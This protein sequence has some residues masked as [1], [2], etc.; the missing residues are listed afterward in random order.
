[1]FGAALDSIRSA[2]APAL[3]WGRRVAAVAPQAAFGLLLL[4]ILA[5]AGYFA[6]YTLSGLDLVGLL[7]DVNVDDSFYYFQIARNLA[8]GQFSTVD[9][10]ITRTN[11]YHPVWM[12]LITP[13]YWVL[14]L[15]TALFGI[16]ALELG[17]IGGSVVV[18]AAAARLCRLPWVA[19]VA[20]PLLL[21]PQ[22]ALWFGLEAACG[23]F[24][25]SL[26]FLALSLLARNPARW[27]PLLAATAFLLP[28]VRLEYLAISLTATAGS[29]IVWL[30][31]GGG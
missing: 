2:L 31:R 6:Y 13:F 30:T 17:L 20:L 11:G 3:P 23:L 1:M 26:L 12:L 22:K 24:A 8:E 15:E 21:Y 7:R 18:L 4:A 19:L 10:G 5:Y 9:G 29:A 14:D 16:K 28:W 25:L 27:W